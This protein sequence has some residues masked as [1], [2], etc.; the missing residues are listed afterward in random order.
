MKEKI[1]FNVGDK[2]LCVVG[3]RLRW[4]QVREVKAV[5]CGH[6]GVRIYYGFDYYVW[7]PQ[8]YVYASKQEYIESLDV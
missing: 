4:V 2:V 7:A 8:E 5:S 1:R 3:A 6:N